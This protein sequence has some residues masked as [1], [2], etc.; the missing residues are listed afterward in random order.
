MLRI[1]NQIIIVIDE[2]QIKN[3]I[4]NVVLKNVID[5]HDFRTRQIVLSIKISSR[6]NFTKFFMIK[7]T[8]FEFVEFFLCDRFTHDDFQIFCFTNTNVAKLL[9]TSIRDAIVIDSNLKKT[10]RCVERYLTIQFLIDIINF[11]QISIRHVLNHQTMN[12]QFFHEYQTTIVIL[13][14]DEKLMIFDINE[15]FSFVMFVHVNDV[16][17]I[18]FHHLQKQITIILIDS[19]INIDK[20]IIEF[21][22]R[23][24][25]FHVI[26]HIVIIVDVIQIHC[27][28]KKNFNNTFARHAQFHFVCCISFFRYQIHRQ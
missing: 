13:M 2:K 6:L 17:D 5:Y 18:K 3:K 25:K 7:F 20:T 21:V 22:Q 4:M 15:I 10:H 26:V 11:E 19:I 14:R 8:K 1:T 24:R 16:D 12:Y 27:I 28:S 9:A 23:V